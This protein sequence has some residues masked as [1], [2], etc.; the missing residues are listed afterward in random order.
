M[1]TLASLY[2]AL[3][4]L[5]VTALSLIILRIGTLM[6]DCPQTGSAARVTALTIC[7]GFAAIGLGVVVLIGALLPILSDMPLLALLTCTG[8][9][10]LCLGLG[11]T[12]AVATFRAVMEPV[13]AKAEP[14]PKPD[15]P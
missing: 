5:G 15:A 13:A 10:S 6:S 2:L 9:A 4:V 7:T 3:G 14:A 12:Q 1:L 11:F 8:L